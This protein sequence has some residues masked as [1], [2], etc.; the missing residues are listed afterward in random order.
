MEQ[1][2]WFLA[3]AKM[4][5]EQTLATQAREKEAITIYMYYFFSPPPP[6]PPL[7]PFSPHAYPRVA[8][9]TLPCLSQWSKVAAMAMQ[10]SSFRPP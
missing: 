5:Q 2:F 4:E 9:S 7:L 3:A 8:I 6:P 1:D 10:T